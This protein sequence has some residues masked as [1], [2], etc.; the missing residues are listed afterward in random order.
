M[1]KMLL[2]VLSLLLVS[3]MANA[4]TELA[5]D[6]NPNYAVSR[7]KYM[8]MADSLNQWHSTT[9]QNTYQAIDFMADKERARN[10]RREFRQQLRLE[11]ARWNNYN[12]RNDG[13]FNSP[14]DY[15][16]NNSYYSPY[17]NNRPN[18]WQRNRFWWW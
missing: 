9:L 5:P 17:G 15:R 4:Q 11:R 12:Y 7:D 3:V 18:R 10:E 13:Y 2:P 1:K 14:Y 8:Q 6:Q 16:N